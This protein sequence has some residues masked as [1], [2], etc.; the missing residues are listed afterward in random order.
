[1]QTTTMPTAMQL[2]EFFSK[3]SRTD[4]PDHVVDDARWRLMDTVGVAL[5]GSRMDYARIV[6][7][8]M[9]EFGGR[10]D[11]SVL[12]TGE[13]LPAPAAAFVN[14]SYAHGPD[15]D[16]THSIAMVHIGC[17]A[18][19]AALS[20]GEWAR[21]TGAQVMTAM[22]AGAEV[23]LR[24][25]AAAPHRFHMR[26]YHATGVVGPF[27][28]AAVTA[29]LRQ[30]NSSQFASGLG[31]VASQAA[32]LLE[33]LHDGSWVKRLHPAWSVQSGITAALLAERGFIGPTRGIEGEWGLYAVL[34]HG[35]E[36][37]ESDLVVRDLGKEWLLPQTTFK[38]YSSGA[39]NHSSMDCVGEIMRRQRLTSA[40][41]V[42]ID[43]F[44]PPECI[45]IVC[46]PRD[47]KIHPGTP[48]HMKFSLPYSVAILAVLGHAG[49]DD[50]TD[51]VFAN[52]EIADLAG[53]VECHAD[54]SM[55]ADNFPA[56]V[57]VTTRDARKFECSV[58]A[59]RGGPG[60][61]MS[62]DDHR[63]KFRANAE[64]VLGRAKTD[65]AMSEIESVWEAP[66][67]K[68]LMGL[69]VAG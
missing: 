59:Q 14:A 25:G 16:D 47:A 31:L 5:A 13:R 55:K 4:L 61:A 27:V 8:L 49:V 1:M 39:W 34:L 44:V 69:L 58:L 36:Q 50:Y 2:A 37:V 22:V 30:M 46:E 29:H 51:E 48:Y 68:R 35:E 62:P 33:G 10:Q 45:P 18:V 43:T 54:A 23:G 24:I 20:V 26:G 56:R 65:E 41:I 66:N 40:D 7:S 15:F 11:A 17:L 21:A 57:V 3:L 28:A 60:N 67:L 12:G 19:P 64:L 52:R 9:T 6:H 32:G 53:R 42:R 38:P 63:K